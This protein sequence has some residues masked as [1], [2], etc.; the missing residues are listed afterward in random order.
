MRPNTVGKSFGGRGKPTRVFTYADLRRIN[1]MLKEG[2]TYR[3]IGQR[4]GVNH[5]RI[6]YLVEELKE[7]PLETI[8]PLDSDLPQGRRREGAEA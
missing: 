8:D 5:Q 6:S 3:A 7:R 2:Y 4:F 1:Q